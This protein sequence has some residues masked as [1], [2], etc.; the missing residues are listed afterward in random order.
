MFLTYRG[1]ENMV[2]EGFFIKQENMGAFDERNILVSYRAE[3]KNLIG[4]KLYDIENSNKN[5]VTQS[6]EISNDR[7]GVIQSIKR[8]ENKN[9]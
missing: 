1:D 4:F 3:F 8:V 5:L 6:F 2:K 7:G 9:N